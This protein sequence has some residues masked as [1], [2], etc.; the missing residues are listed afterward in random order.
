MALLEQYWRRE[1]DGETF[2]SEETQERDELEDWRLQHL[3][4]NIQRLSKSEY[5]SLS[6]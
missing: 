1:D 5:E 2:S 4:E 3:E 6:D